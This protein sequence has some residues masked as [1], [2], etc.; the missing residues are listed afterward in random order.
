MEE[1]LRFELQ[2]HQG[3]LK[4]AQAAGDSIVTAGAEVKVWDL[5]T[6]ELRFEIPVTSTA[7]ITP[8]GSAIY[9]DDGDSLLRRVPITAAGLA[10]LAR[11]RVTRALTADEC[12]R[13]LSP[14][15]C[16]NPAQ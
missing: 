1:A 3:A 16:T 8:D 4:F 5:E 10:E 2:A 14:E 6:G 12:L 15:D 9:Y 11:S 13:F 7:V